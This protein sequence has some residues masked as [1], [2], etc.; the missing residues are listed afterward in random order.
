MVLESAISYGKTMIV[1]GSDDRLPVTGATMLS[2]SGH[3]VGVADN[4]GVMAQPDS[5][6]YPIAI[7]SMGYEVTTITEGGDTVML[8]A[9]DNAL[10]EISVTA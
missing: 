4:N 9:V 2:A 8:N 10:P 1:I 6:I 3:I 5:I 7:R